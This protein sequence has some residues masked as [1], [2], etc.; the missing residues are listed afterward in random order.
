MTHCHSE[1]RAAWRR[2]PWPA[3][4]LIL[5][6]SVAAVVAQPLQAGMAN[7]VLHPD[8]G[9]V[10]KLSGP[11]Q[12]SCCS[13]EDV[14]AV[15]EAVNLPLNELVRTLFFRFWKVNLWKDCPFWKDGLFCTNRNCAVEPADESEVPDEWKS[16]P[17]GSINLEGS[18]TEYS[19][20][21]GGCSITDKDFCILD[22]E[23][24]LSDGTCYVDLL[25]NPE[26]FTGYS[27]EPANRVWRAIYEENCFNLIGDGTTPLET[28]LDR[29]RAVEAACVEKRVFYRLVSGL[30]SSI[31]VHICT[32]WLNR[33]TGEWHPN[34]DCFVHRV[35]KFPERVNNV[36]FN[37]AVVLRALRKLAPYLR[38]YAF[39]S[40]N[41]TEDALTRE[42][43]ERVL[44]A[45][46][47][48]PAA[49]DEKQ[50]FA[51]QDSKQLMREIKGAFRNISR[52]MDCVSCDKCK[53]W[54]KLQVTGLGTALKILFSLD[55]NYRNYRLSRTEIVTLVNAFQRY[56]NT[57]K[58]ITRFKAMWEARS[59][60]TERA[61][62]PRPAERA[63][64]ERPPAN[65]SPPKAEP[66][67]GP[68][69][70]PVAPP[71]TEGARRFFF[72]PGGVLV[73]LAAAALAVIVFMV[74]GGYV[75]PDPRSRTK[76]G[77]VVA[78]KK[79]KKVA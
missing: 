18:S 13:F 17:L 77:Q 60:A 3:V 2:S 49:F 50:L 38:E 24:A 30:H 34:L 11:I 29:A 71:L 19:S 72:S 28:E 36:Y 37:Y 35:G 73:V 26:R 70:Q 75:D 41:T 25:K 1:P 16:G 42:L 44:D 31:S 4:L 56:S 46:A 21:F 66:D 67:S 33:T 69:P 54:G 39:C 57:L 58:S 27:G 47:G 8:E 7:A 68:A 45:P 48:C 5:F 63:D 55:D 59:Q 23:N 22:S 61:P 51:G 43:L 76:A 52:I 12:D 40:S 10:C 65:A 78:K 20:V 74:L 6:A 14:Q 79:A 64:A 9:D 53:M 62:V 15:N 32:D